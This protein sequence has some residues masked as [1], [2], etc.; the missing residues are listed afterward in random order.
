LSSTLTVK[1]VVN[2]GL[3]EGP[4]KRTA[5]GFLRKWDP[6]G[7]GNPPKTSP[8]G[9]GGPLEKRGE[10][11]VSTIA[12]GKVTQGGKRPKYLSRAYGYL[13]EVLVP[14]SAFKEVEKGGKGHEQGFHRTQL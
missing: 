10:S 9:K 14:V 8:P 6:R 4:K 3:G 2:T 7:G 1:N 11:L 12:G 13:G 5:A